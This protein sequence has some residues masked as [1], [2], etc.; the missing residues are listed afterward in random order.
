MNI[1]DQAVL[2]ATELNKQH[3]NFVVIGRGA[4]W[5]QGVRKDQHFVFTF[6]VECVPERVDSFEAF[7]CGPLLFTCPK[8]LGSEEATVFAEKLLAKSPTKNCFDGGICNVAS[9]DD[10]TYLIEQEAKEPAPVDYEGG[11]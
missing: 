6:L 2:V 4:L 9:I 3:I 5:I 1:R 8:D 7:D 10:A 11:V